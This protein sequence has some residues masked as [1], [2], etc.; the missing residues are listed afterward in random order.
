MTR[1]RRRQ[2]AESTD[3]GI[4]WAGLIFLIGFVVISLWGRREINLKKAAEEAAI[5]ED[6][7]LQEET[8]ARYSSIPPCG[9]DS[10]SACDDGDPCTID[11]CHK[12]WYEGG[13]YSCENR[14]RRE[15]TLFGNPNP[16]AI[17]LCD[18]AT[19]KNIIIPRLNDSFCINEEQGFVPGRCQ[20]EKCVADSIEVCND[21]NPC[22]SDFQSEYGCETDELLDGTLCG[23]NGRCYHGVCHPPMNYH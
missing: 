2:L 23:K 11:Y 18:R 21:E 4:A 16:C 7:R 17:T 15:T 6:W 12:N 8:S 1:T 19:G 20:G 10:D 3:K 13:I 9:I 14:F 22:T 5:E